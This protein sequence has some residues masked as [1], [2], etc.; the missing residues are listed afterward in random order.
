MNLWKVKGT[1]R[2]P[3]MVVRPTPNF[4]VGSRLEIQF[5]AVDERLI[6]E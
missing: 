6:G 4:E 3:I 5:H 2:P 1:P